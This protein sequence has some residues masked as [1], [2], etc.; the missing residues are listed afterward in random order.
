MVE[1][2]TG[3]ITLLFTDIDLWSVQ[4]IGFPLVFSFQN[5]GQLCGLIAQKAAR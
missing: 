3:T 5:I 2:P 1:L 4:Y